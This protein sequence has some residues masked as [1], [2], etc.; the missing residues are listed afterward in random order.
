[1]EVNCTRGEG[2]V[3]D[4]TKSFDDLNCIFCLLKGDKVDSMTNIG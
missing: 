4:V 1:M 3:N 2:L